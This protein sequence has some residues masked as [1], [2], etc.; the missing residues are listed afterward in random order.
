MPLET[1]IVSHALRRRPSIVV[2]LSCAH[3]MADRCPGS[4]A[5]RDARAGGLHAGFG[6]SS[7]D[8]VERW[9]FY[10]RGSS[11]PHRDFTAP[12]SRIGRLMSIHAINRPVLATPPTRV[13]GEDLA[14]APRLT[15]S[16]ELE[17]IA[18]RFGDRPTQLSEFLEATQGRGFDLL[19]ICLAV[20]FLTPIPL[21][22]LS[23][24]FGFVV[25]IIGGR[26]ALG[27]RVWLPKQLL[28]RELPPRLLTKALKAAGRLI[29]F[30]E[31]FLKP[32]LSLLQKSFMFQRM[33]GFLIMF[34]GILLLL[35]LPLPLT[36][37]L[38]A[39]TIIL[40]AAGGNGTGRAVLLGWLRSVHGDPRLF[41]S[42]LV[43]RR[44][45]PW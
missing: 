40:L 13:C 43:W 28:A 5:R 26:L 15:F 42:D 11:G 7:A 23:T 19:L 35:P 18:A 4:D 22:G 17:N 33:A 6:P 10:G 45:S 12:E 39:L 44:E 27:R 29:R 34:S 31:F 37:S 24:P 16:R 8:Q 30:L 20:P 32:R 1:A 14:R 21:P 9:P 3:P 38:P 25:A 2:C 41:R 36:N